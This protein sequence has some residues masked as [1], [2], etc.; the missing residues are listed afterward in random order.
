MVEMPRGVRRDT[1]NTIGNADATFKRNS[2]DF[3]YLRN[4]TVDLN[5]G[6]TLQTSSDTIDT[7]DTVDDNDLAF[8]RNNDSFTS[9]SQATGKI[10]LQKI[11]KYR[12]VLIS[13]LIKQFKLII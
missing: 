4:N 9:F 1:F 7:I 6:K 8:K 11:Q 12:A 2:I 3:F 10:I 13:L 5:A